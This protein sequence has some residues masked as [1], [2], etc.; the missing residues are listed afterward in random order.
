[1]RAL[2]LVLRLAFWLALA[3][4]L[5]MALMPHPPSLLPFNVWDKIQHAAAFG[6]LSGLAAFAYPR[7]ALTRLGEHLSFVGALVEILQAM[8]VIHRD[9]DIRDWIADTVAIIVMLGL[10]WVY[11][12]RF[13]SREP[14]S[15]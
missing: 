1:M 3:F 5:V 13:G 7:A 6:V 10:V 4:T 12:T 15:I 9:C 14:G 11:R 8:P 2:T